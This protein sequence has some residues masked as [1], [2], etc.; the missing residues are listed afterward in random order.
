MGNP[1]IYIAAVKA[2]VTQE[3]YLWATMEGIVRVVLVDGSPIVRQ[4]LSRM[5]SRIEGVEVVGEAAMAQQVARAIAAYRPDVVVLDIWLPDGS[6]L[7]WL[8]QWTNRQPAP[9]FLVM[10]G[11]VSEPLKRACLQGGAKYFFDK[12]SQL[13][14]FLETIR[15]L[16]T[17]Q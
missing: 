15:N 10:T 13:D 9:I 4:S 14:E 1:G 3:S 11:R 17:G 6:A 8:P 7:P 2:A 12:S 16:A 5:L